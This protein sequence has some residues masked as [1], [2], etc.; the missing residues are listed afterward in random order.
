VIFAGSAADGKAAPGK[1]DAVTF[2]KAWAHYLE[3]LLRKANLNKKP[4]RH[5]ANAVKLGDSFIL[6]QWS[7]WT[8]HAM[9]EAP[10]S[11]ADWHAK[12]TRVHGP[13]SAN[14]A[15]E[16]V[17]A[18]Y[19]RWGKRDITLPERLP[20]KA[21]DWNP[22]EPSQ[23]ALAPAD[24]KTWRAAWDKLGS[25]VHK[26]YFLFCLLAGVRPGEGARIR[27]QDIDTGART[28]SIKD[29][30]TPQ[31][32]RDITLPLTKEMAYAVAMAV[33][34]PPISPTIRMTGL[35]G[36]KPGEVRVVPRK[37]RHHEITD[38]DLVFP[39]CKQMPSRSGLPMAGNALRHTFKT[40]HVELGISETLSALL[41]GHALDGVSPKYVSEIIVVRGPAI[42]EAQEKISARVFGLLGLKLGGHN[43]A[44]LV[45][46]A[47]SRTARPLTRVAKAKFTGMR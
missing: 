3:H 12:M 2:E 5:H 17:R 31:G 10:G 8:L 24:F 26:G 41:M 7:K 19:K 14:R 44:P 27:L 47:P 18:T 37:K 15:A 16:L 6:P 22:E 21:I 38:T 23:A 39:G 35:R 36:M 45:P 33:N 1:R 11:V 43:D 13:V 40:L 42:R 25:D 20:T 29:V 30:K 9:S 46:D 4:P 34:A 28:F 32:Q